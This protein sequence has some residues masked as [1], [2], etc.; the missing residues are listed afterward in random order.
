MCVPS[1]RNVV[2]DCANETPQSWNAPPDKY[3]YTNLVIKLRKKK[4][5]LRH[6]SIT[7]RCEI[8]NQL[9]PDTDSWFL[10]RGKTQPLATANSCG[11]TV[12]TPDERRA[13]GIISPW[14]LNFARKIRPRSNLSTINLTLNM[15]LRKEWPVTNISL[16]FHLNARRNI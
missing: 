4:R 5:K 6:G 7:Y 3:S 9:H 12:S 15:G 11:L 10:G 14:K 1:V 8:I 2:L 13:S 16:H